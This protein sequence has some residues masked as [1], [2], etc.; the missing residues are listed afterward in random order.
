MSLTGTDRKD[1][2]FAK[3]LLENPSLAMRITS[4]VG[5]PIERGFAMLPKSWSPIVDNA[6]KAALQ[7]A[8]GAALTTMDEGKH[9]NSRDGLHRML[10]TAT[11]AAG[12]AF[13]L[14]ALAVELPLST[15]I[16]L[17]SIVDIA[18]SEGENVREPEAKM[19]CLEVFALGGR[20]T[21]DDAAESAYFAVRSAL[22][23]AV[24]EAAVH[25]AQ[26]GFAQKSAPAMV[27]LIS[28]I[29]SRFSIS[30]GEKAAAQAVPIIGAAGGAAINAIFIDHFQDMARGHFIVRRLERSHGV[31]TVRAQY[32]EL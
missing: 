19:A 26:H 16:M 1:L 14:P 10:A 12:G 4:Y 15:T 32:L 23:R 24:S 25:I 31:E 9:R 13:G 6:T 17:R 29:A 21:G 2:S 27:R 20:V 30:V 18:A 8:L 28:Q 22:G 5:V 3:E 11:G 7:G